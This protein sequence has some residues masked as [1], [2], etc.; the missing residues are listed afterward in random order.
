MRSFIMKN[1]GTPSKL[2]IILLTSFIILTSTTSMNISAQNE[3][4]TLKDTQ[5]TNQPVEAEPEPQTEP[6]PEPQQNESE[7][8]TRVQAIFTEEIS[9]HVKDMNN[10]NLFDYLVLEL[11]IK[12]EKPGYYELGSKLILGENRPLIYVYKDF[13]TEQEY[14]ELK[15]RFE[16]EPIYSSQVSGPYLCELWITNETDEIVSTMEYNTNEYSYL[17]FEHGPPPL[18]MVGRFGDTCVDRDSNGLFDT[19]VFHFII[20]VNEPGTYTFL[21]GLFKEIIK[22]DTK[23]TEAEPEPFYYLVTISSLI[24]DLESGNNTIKLNFVG[25]RI[26]LANYNGPYHVGLWIEPTD[27]DMKEVNQD[28]KLYD[29]ETL[30]EI[31]RERFLWPMVGESDLSGERVFET[32]D[33]RITQFEPP[34]KIAEL[35]KNVKESRIDLDNDDLIDYL[36]FKVEVVINEPGEYLLWGRIETDDE[37]KEIWAENLTYLRKGTYHLSLKF[38]GIEIYQAKLMGILKIIFI[39]K[40]KPSEGFQVLDRFE[41]KTIEKYTYNRFESELDKDYPEELDDEKRPYAKLDSEGVVTKTNVMEIYTTRTRPEITF[42][43]ADTEDSE[44]R[45]KLIFQKLI[46]YDDLNNN[47]VYDFGEEHFVVFLEDTHWEI[48]DL[49]YSVNQNYGNYVEFR[50]YSELLAGNIERL[51]EE[52]LENLSK[53]TYMDPWASVEF[54]FLVSSNNYQESYPFNYEIN[55]DTELKI[56][57]KI[58]I[59]KPIDIDGI[60]LEQLMFDEEKTIGFM[61]R[62]KEGNFVYLPDRITDEFEMRRFKV[63][64]SNQKQWVMFVDESGKEYGFYS[65]VPKINLTYYNGYCE[66]VEIT[67]SYVTD[68]KGFRL[69]TN[70]PYKEEIISIEHDPSVGMIEESRPTRQLEA[71]NG[72]V[73][74]LFN[75]FVYIIASVAAIVFI[76]LL[77]SG[78]MKDKTGPGKRKERINDNVKGKGRDPRKRSD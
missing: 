70:Y 18:E 21:A 78:Q 50:L 69:F 67:S 35:T 13:E 19:L 23:D 51:S 65:W 41:Y 46:G 64:S 57:I 73:E 56:D 25:P 20:K 30:L 39:I 9:D 29:E 37:L 31:Y 16:G 48:S 33:Y 74:I 36:Y 72:L 58:K 34:P 32:K 8:I 12:I 24:I 47:G 26:H 44:A 60:C 68:G 66:T 10:N 15:L 63:E 42:W 55:G 45:F 62:E 2:L 52:K 3:N 54:R 61:T 27:E 14:I 38:S 53:E 11:T 28:R 4:L 7:P 17:D 76:F 75:P 59:H 1:I 22:E 71:G 6:E 5:T 77:R 43:F 40:G 49:I